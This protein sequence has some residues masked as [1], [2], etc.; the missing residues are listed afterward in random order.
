MSKKA[1]N[2]LKEYQN[3]FKDNDKLSKKF[4]FKLNNVVLEFNIDSNT[5][6][7][8]TVFNIESNTI[9]CLVFSRNIPNS[10][11][12]LKEEYPKIEND[13]LLIF[14]GSAKDLKICSTFIEKFIR[15]YKNINNRA[16]CKFHHHKLVNL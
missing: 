14:E 6:V 16:A 7:F 12:I 3:Y 11:N 5:I 2:I 8:D 1:E 4:I 9:K 13:K 15:N 10:I